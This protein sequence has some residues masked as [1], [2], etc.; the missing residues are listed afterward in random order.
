M[1]NRIIVPLEAVWEGTMVLGGVKFMGK[2]E[3]FDSK[4]GWAF[5]FWKP[6]MHTAH[7]T[8][9]FEMDVVSIHSEMGTITL[10]KQINGSAAEWAKLGISLTLD[11]KQ[12]ET[13]KGGSSGQNP[14]ARQVSNHQPNCTLKQIDKHNPTADH[15]SNNTQLM[16][17]TLKHQNGDRV[18]PLSKLQIRFLYTLRTISKCHNTFSDFISHFCSL[19]CIF[20]AH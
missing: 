3:V 7:A 15:A 17:N 9:N 12:W 4:G 1:A 5:L 11:A 2:F 10:S 20:A 19:F 16:T 13:Q 18:T 14:P 8:H 6:L